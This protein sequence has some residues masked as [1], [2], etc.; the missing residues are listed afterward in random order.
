[1]TDLGR[2]VFGLGALALGAVGLIWG[3]FATVWQPVP[4][5]TPG[6]VALAYAAAATQLAGGLAL[7]WRRP[8]RIAGPVLAALYLAFTLLWVRRILVVPQ[9]MAVWGGAAEE[10]TLVIAGLLIWAG[11][12]PTGSVASRQV[13]LAGRL[14]FGACAIAFGLNHFFNL[15]ETGAMVP[16]WLPPGQLFWAV[17]TGLGHAFAGVALLTGVR[18]VLAARL[19]TAMFVVFGVL[20]WAPFLLA[21]PTDHT[22]LAGNAINLILT[23]AAWVMADQVAAA[24][25]PGLAPDP[26]A[27]SESEPLPA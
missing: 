19:L 27:G 1:M 2:R 26:K 4:A 5:E 6:R 17:A 11:L 7:Q 8:A 9:I 14:L 22:V 24:A 21:H 23:G 25:R 18:A 16:Q 12:Q 13:S 15:K 3:D 20:V 10:L